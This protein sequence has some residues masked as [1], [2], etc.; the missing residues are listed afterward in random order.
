MNYVYDLPI[1]TKDIVISVDDDF[2]EE[3]LKLD[4]EFVR[5]EVKGK[6]GVVIDAEYDRDGIDYAETRCKMHKC[7][8]M[9]TDFDFWFDTDSGKYHLGIYIGLKCISVVC[10]EMQK[11]EL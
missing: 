4:I 2:D 6:L 11:T 10:S 1:E 8:P 7:D 9:D 5:N 3:V